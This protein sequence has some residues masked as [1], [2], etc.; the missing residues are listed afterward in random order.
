[1]IF[2]PC[3]RHFKEVLEY[4]EELKLPYRID[5]FIVRGLDYYNRTVLSFCGN[6]I[7]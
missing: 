3:R 1:M 5:P 4:A 6:G 7:R 2:A